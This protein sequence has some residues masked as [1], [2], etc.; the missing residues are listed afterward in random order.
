MY[1]QEE[2]KGNSS[3]RVIPTYGMNHTFFEYA[4]MAYSED[5]YQ[6]KKE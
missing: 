1:H 5:V 6:L 2:T 4:L 3:K